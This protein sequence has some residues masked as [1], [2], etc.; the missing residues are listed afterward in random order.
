MLTATVG[1]PHF[2]SAA[3]IQPFRRP[4]GTRK[5]EI[6]VRAPELGLDAVWSQT[7]IPG[8]QRGC[9]LPSPSISTSSNGFPDPLESPLDSFDQWGCGVS[10]ARHTILRK[11]ALTVPL[12]CRPQDCA[13]VP[14]PPGWHI[15]KHIFP[16]G[17]KISRLPGDRCYLL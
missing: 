16:A 12:M 9:I 14:V 13:P 6:L 7:T 1:S 11:H 2:V 5:C 8:I 10:T 15:M 17:Q 3:R 4:W